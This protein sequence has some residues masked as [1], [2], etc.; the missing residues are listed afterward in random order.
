MTVLLKSIF[1]SE[2]DTFLNKVFS[3][4]QEDDKN[5]TNAIKQTYS[6]LI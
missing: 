4:R 2:E 3:D 6:S 1:E 5:A